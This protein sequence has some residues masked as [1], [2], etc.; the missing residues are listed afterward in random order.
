MQTIVVVL[1]SFALF[2]A[3]PRLLESQ[4]CCLV[5]TKG[6]WSFIELEPPRWWNLVITI[7]TTICTIR[8]TSA[9]FLNCSYAVVS[10]KKVTHLVSS[11]SLAYFICFHYFFP[12]H[13]NFSSICFLTSNHT[14]GWFCARTSLMTCI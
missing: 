4:W 6:R 10:S 12:I 7:I 1:C 3:N 14:S 13:C 11:L 8:A 5:L 2:I 9:F